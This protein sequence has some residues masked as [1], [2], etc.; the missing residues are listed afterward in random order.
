[1]AKEATRKARALCEKPAKKAEK[2]IDRMTST[3]L[4]DF[5]K[6]RVSKEAEGELKKVIAFV[7]KYPGARFRVEGH[8][9]GI[10]SKKYNQKL[11][12]KRAVAVKKYLLSAGGIDKKMI[13]AKGYGKTKPVAPNKTKDGKDNPE[14]RARNRRVEI[15]VLAE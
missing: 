11:S 6:S 4:F 15:L 14:G 12:E 5:N 13:S 8:T 9:D 2:I 10:G 7:K 1:M 3:V